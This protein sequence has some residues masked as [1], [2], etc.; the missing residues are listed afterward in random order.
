MIRRIAMTLALF[1]FLFPVALQAQS[2]RGLRWPAASTVECDDTTALSLNPA[3]LGFLDG[4]EARY[5]HTELAD[6]EGEGDGVFLGARVLGP[7]ALGM[8]FEFLPL[9]RSADTTFRYT[10][11]TAFGFGRVGSFGLSVHR[12]VNDR[13]DGY[14]GLVSVDL[15]LMIRPLH[16]LAVGAAVTDLNTPVLRQRAIRRRYELGLGFRPATDRVYLGAEVAMEESTWNT[17]ARLRLLFEPTPGLTLGGDLLLSPRDDQLGIALSTVLGFSFGYVGVAGGAY[18]GGVDEAPFDGYAVTAWAGSKMQRPLFRRHHQVVVLDLAGRLPERPTTVFFGPRTSTFTE[19]LVA[20][21]SLRDDARVEAVLLKL[22][23]LEVGWA[24]AQELR[25]ALAALQTA[26]KKIVCHVTDTDT[27]ELYIAAQ[28]DHVVAHP[29]AA[30]MLT[31]LSLTRTFLRGGL[32]KLGIEAQF[33][34]IG[35]YKSYPE[36]FTRY[37]SSEPARE[38][39]ERILDVL[40]GQVLAGLAA[41]RN[42]SVDDARGLVDG[43]PYIASEARDRGIV[44]AVAFDDELEGVVAELLGHPAVLRDDWFERH[45]RRRGWGPKE[46]LAVVPIQGTLV[47]GTSLHIPFFGIHF[48]GSETLREAIAQA[49]D[50]PNVVAILLRIDSGGGAALAAER[51]RRAVTKA[52]E[53]KPVIASLVN[54]AAS[55]GY[56][57]ATAAAE[58]VA[59]RATVTGS[60]GIFVGKFVVKGLFEKLGIRREVSERGAHA[61]L[62]SLDEPWDESE[63]ARVRAGLEAAYRAFIANVAEGRNMEPGEVEKVAGGRVWIG[64]DALEHRLVDADTGFAGALG[65]V[66]R[67]LGR[68]EDHRYGLRFFPRGGWQLHLGLSYTAAPGAPVAAERSLDL[69]AAAVEALQSLTPVLAGFETLAP[70]AIMPEAFTLD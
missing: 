4:F 62:R 53:K 33:V 29:G 43:G 34:A 45:E 48:A 20:L 26:G 36:T 30:V 32:D 68:P 40:Y 31:G 10:F 2:S 41:G 1:A 66:N 46:K 61:S 50:D 7:L 65:A 51:V 13:N 25:N 23:G 16:W 56:D 70:L 39:R 28:A 21:D 54:V 19:L 35:D 17:D 5:L 42:V 18:F 49:A 22:R 63:I 12:F 11:G 27:R 37:E 15:G 59:S 44:D 69:P 24:Q 38:A 60:I 58:I 52:R 64:T 6:L 14:D 8:G 57:I 9:G 3:G 55:G 47:P 67:A